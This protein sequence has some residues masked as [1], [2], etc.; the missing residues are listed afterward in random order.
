[1]RRKWK[2]CTICGRGYFEF[3]TENGWQEDVCKECD[4]M[5]CD[6]LED[7]GQWQ[8]LDVMTYNGFEV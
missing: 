8:E 1:M 6:S 3:Q 2:R 7:E 5:L 4:I